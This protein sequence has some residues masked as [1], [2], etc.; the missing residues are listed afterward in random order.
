ML[1]L[2]TSIFT[3][4]VFDQA[5]ELFSRFVWTENSGL[6][7]NTEIKAYS[8]PGGTETF[9][10]MTSSF[11]AN[12][13]LIYPEI[14]DLGVLDYS[15]IPLDLILD[16]EKTLE[17]IKKKEITSDR[18]TNDYI[19]II[20]SFRLNKLPMISLLWYA[21][22]QALSEVRYGVRIKAI[23][24][25]QTDFLFIN[26]VFFKEFDDW[27]LDELIFDGKTYAKLARQN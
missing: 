3:T 26:L 7:S 9:P 27:L 22:P 24:E 6:N 2:Q 19:S 4:T 20:S 5:N 11:V 23:I 21:R 17:Q 10:L 25:N 13:S 12:K 14:E 18:V 8:L 1:V 15:S 16:I